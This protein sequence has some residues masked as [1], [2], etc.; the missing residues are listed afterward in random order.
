VAENEVSLKSNQAK[1]QNIKTAVATTES[2]NKEGTT[3]PKTIKR[4][5][6][7][8]KNVPNTSETNIGGLKD[9]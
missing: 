1:K 2:V 4:E 3:R 9:S 6:P 5:V 7:K 8:K